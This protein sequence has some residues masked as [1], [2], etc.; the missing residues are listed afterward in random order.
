MS[1]KSMASVV[2][3]AVSRASTGKRSP[4]AWST[5]SKTPSALETLSRAG[6]G[7]RSPSAWSKSKES[8]EKDVE[9]ATEDSGGEKDLKDAIMD[10]YL[11]EEL[12]QANMDQ[13][14]NANEPLGCWET[15]VNHVSACWRTADMLIGEERESIV[16][17]ST[18]ELAI[19]VLFMVIL[20]FGKIF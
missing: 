15:F 5:K 11:E 10:P 16:R 17:T 8:E 14:N 4:S 6:T 3:E 2:Q 20:M 19:Y 7:K 12:A 1:A 9:A 18:R 13:C